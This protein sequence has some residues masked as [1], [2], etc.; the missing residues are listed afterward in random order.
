MPFHSLAV[1]NEFLDIAEKAGN[2]IGPMKLQKLVYFAHGWYLAFKDAPLIHEMVEAWEYGPVISSI[3]HEFKEF[4]RG[5]ITGRATRFIKK[6]SKNLSIPFLME[7]SP[8]QDLDFAKSLISQV[9]KVYGK[10][11]GIQL[12]NMTHKSDTPWYKICQQH[13]GKPPRGL[14]IPEELIK[15]HFK[16]KLNRS[17]ST[18]NV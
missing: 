6:E 7:D 4:G 9:W 1:A 13:N 8:N 17:S 12:S 18:K 15:S 3:Y 11:S 5:N 10:F 16:E 14:D 2:P